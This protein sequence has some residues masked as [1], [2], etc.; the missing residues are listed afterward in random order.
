MFLFFF[1]FF[2]K[3]RLS[4]HPA[5]QLKNNFLVDIPISDIEYLHELGK[6]EE[7]NR[8]SVILKDRKSKIKFEVISLHLL[9]FSSSQL[10]THFLQWNMVLLEVSHNRL[11]AFGKMPDK[12]KWKEL[13]T[14]LTSVL[15]FNPSPTFNIDENHKEHHNEHFFRD[16]ETDQKGDVVR[17]TD[18]TLTSF[19]RD[20]TENLID[21]PA[22][23][24]VRQV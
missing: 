17:K 13:V 15:T 19:K 4:V 5:P 23:T 18:V 20:A 7:E 2:F 24:V 6:S 8:L 1:F 9:V 11:F 3:Q 21:F 16:K 14:Q 22:K 10:L 12:N